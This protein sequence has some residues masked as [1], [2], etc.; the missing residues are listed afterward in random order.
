MRARQ[1]KREREREA[2]PLSINAGLIW[3]RTIL[4]DYFG[5]F[6]FIAIFCFD[7][8]M[9]DTFYEKEEKKIQAKV[10]EL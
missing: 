8:R 10:P 1:E 4:R 9:I 2:L 3:S 5:K 7:S 6:I